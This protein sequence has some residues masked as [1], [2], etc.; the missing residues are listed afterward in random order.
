MMNMK[1]TF[2]IGH[3]AT[4]LEITAKTL[5]R[6]E[7]EGRLIPATLTVSNRRHYTGSRLRAAL[8]NDD[9]AGAPDQD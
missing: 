9:A 1:S 5:Q 2:R 8:E 6:W 4:L 3:A 7:C